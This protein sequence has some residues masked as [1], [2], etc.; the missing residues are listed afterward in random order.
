[1]AGNVTGLFDAQRPRQGRAGLRGR[2][3]PHRVDL[4]AVP[5]PKV[6]AQPA[7]CRKMLRPRRRHQPVIRQ[8]GKPGSDIGRAQ[9][10][11]RRQI[12]FAAQVPRQEAKESGKRMAIGFHGVGGGMA[13]L[14]HPLQ[15]TPVSRLGRHGWDNGCARR[16]S[17]AFGRP[18]RHQTGLS[19][20]T[21]T[22]NPE[23]V[24]GQ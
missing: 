3:Q 5:P 19:P 22:R 2:H 10:R 16:G 7:Q 15:E 23:R 14:L 8:R 1:M 24:C 13:F 18:P 4:H 21:V 6:A 9:C 11:Q 12:G 17:L 20:A